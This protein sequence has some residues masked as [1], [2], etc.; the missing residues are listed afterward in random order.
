MA[1]KKDKK[2]NNNSVRINI[3]LISLAVIVVVSIITFAF[4]YGSLSKTVSTNEQAVSSL[5]SRQDIII[6]KLIDIMARLGIIESKI[7]DYLSGH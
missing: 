5:Y 4:G 3:A 2:N 6:D 7:T 1:D